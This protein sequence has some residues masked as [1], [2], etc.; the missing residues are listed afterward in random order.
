MV[1][2]YGLKP[3][4]EGS[5]S[6][7]GVFI[8]QEEYKEALYGEK[9]HRQALSPSAVGAH[10]TLDC[11]RPSLQV[12]RP[13]MEAAKALLE[14]GFTVVGLSGDN[15]ETFAAGNALLNAA[16][17]LEDAGALGRMRPGLFSDQVS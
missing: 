8:N 12:G 11:S 10:V 3:R 4:E 15:P 16:H 1:L 2:S 17:D 6:C 7:C 9:I 5:R 13:L 14:A